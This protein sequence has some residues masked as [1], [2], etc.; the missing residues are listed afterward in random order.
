MALDN[1][2]SSY[3][4]GRGG[5]GGRGGGRGG[6]G[7]GGE[8]VQYSL[9]HSTRQKLVQYRFA[10]Q[11]LRGVLNKLIPGSCFQGRSS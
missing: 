7:G 4:Q 3:L 6:G 1:T 2:Y 10:L 5:G 8:G 11:L 9:F